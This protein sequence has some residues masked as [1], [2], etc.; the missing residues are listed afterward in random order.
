MGNNKPYSD[1]FGI[2]RC[3][4]FNEQ[5]HLHRKSNIKASKKIVIKKNRR[6]QTING[7]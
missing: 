2:L 4:S 6:F 5:K 1:N 3:T 7:E